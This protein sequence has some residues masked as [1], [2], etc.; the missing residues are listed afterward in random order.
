MGMGMGMGMGHYSVSSN[1]IVLS[2]GL[3]VSGTPYFGPFCLYCVSISLLPGSMLFAPRDHL[4]YGLWN[5]TRKKKGE[6]KI[7]GFRPLGELIDS[8]RD[9]IS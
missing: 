6:G 2:H 4:P 7:P 5:S 1:A 3:C 8:N 9:P